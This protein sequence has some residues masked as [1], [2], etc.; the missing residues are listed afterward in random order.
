MGNRQHHPE[1][2]EL[3]GAYAID[4]VEAGERRMVERHLR[5]CRTCDV[6]VRDHR[7]VAAGLAPVGFAPEGIWAAIADAME[8]APP[9]F[10][11]A[12]VVSF[13]DRRSRRTPLLGALTAV[14]AAAVAVLCVRLVDQG[15]R[16]DQV[17]TAMAEDGVQRAAVVALASLTTK[18]VD[19]RTADGGAAARIALLPDD[20]GFLIAD[21][22]AGLEAN[23]TYQLWALVDGQ[24]I[25][26]GIL[27]PR[28]KV[29]V[30]N[31]RGP[32]TGF[33]VTEEQVP[34]VAASNQPPVVMGWVRS[35]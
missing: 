7:E 2:E 33:A 10:D 21:G 9:P 35:A 22:L 12:S 16:I 20:Q 19:L 26:A 17:Q 13:A 15:R 30:F 23:R 29:T 25:A 6:E 28:P 1:V 14:A 18:T 5:T 24:R 4:A 27:G 3:L 32:V 11:F 34:G 31:V 8:E